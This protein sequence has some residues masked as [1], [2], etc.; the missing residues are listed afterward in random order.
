[1][2]ADESPFT[3]AAFVRD[4]VL[5]AF[6]DC[7]RPLGASLIAV[8]GIT[9]DDASHGLL[10][11]APVRV[12]PAT[13]PFPTDMPPMILDE[14]DLIGV[15]FQVQ[16]HRCVPVLTEAGQVP[17]AADQEAAHRVLLDDSAALYRVLR[18]PDL[19]AATD[20]ERSNVDMTYLEPQGGFGAVEARFSL[21]LSQYDWCLTC[22]PTDEGEV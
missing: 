22:T 2:R 21:G 11:V 6:K 4:Y 19:V 8:G 15:E 16:I 12:F 14:A 13:T 9:V 17:A 7:G 10:V 20:W 3:V 1:M 5:E 18:S